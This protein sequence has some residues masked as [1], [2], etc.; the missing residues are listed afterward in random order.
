MNLKRKNYFVITYCVCFIFLIADLLIGLFQLIDIMYKDE[1][2]LN[3]G[4]GQLRFI[5]ILIDLIS[6]IG[7]SLFLLILWRKVFTEIHEKENVIYN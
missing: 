1:N 3:T 6:L 2:F 4:N 5:N 7:V